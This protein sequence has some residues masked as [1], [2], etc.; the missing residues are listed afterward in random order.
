MSH[1]RL[2]ESGLG[3]GGSGKMPLLGAGGRRLS[4]S[5][6]GRPNSFSDRSSQNSPNSRP[7]RSQYAIAEVDM[8]MEMDMNIPLATVITHA[9]DLSEKHMAM[10]SKAKGHKK[11]KVN[12]TKMQDTIDEGLSHGI[13]HWPPALRQ[14]IIQ[15]FKRPCDERAAGQYLAQHHWPDGL[16]NTIYKSCKKIP[17]RFFIVDDSGIL[18]CQR[19]Q[20]HDSCVADIH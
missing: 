16:K 8:D 10:E 2:S 19:R 4:E 3:L 1:R 18:F 13:K 17:L 20:M 6:L 14:K 7:N 5:G 12:E 9:N 11:H 15:T